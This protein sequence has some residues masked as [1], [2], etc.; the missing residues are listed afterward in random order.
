MLGDYYSYILEKARKTQGRAHLQTGSIV[1]VGE[2]G[3]EL[4]II[5][6]QETTCNDKR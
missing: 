2:G 6:T 3:H 5:H 1:H 4:R